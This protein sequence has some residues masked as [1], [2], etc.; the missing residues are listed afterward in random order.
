M[1]QV[2]DTSDT[3][4]PPAEPVLSYEAGLLDETLKEIGVARFVG[5]INSGVIDSVAGYKALERY[6]LQQSDRPLLSR[7]SH[8]LM[9]RLDTFDRTLRD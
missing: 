5:R 2:L 6:A 9:D 3:S 7:L 1:S 8:L 4:S